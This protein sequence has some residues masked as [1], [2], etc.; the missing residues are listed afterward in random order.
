LVDTNNISIS[1][2]IYQYD[3]L[4]IKDGAG[5]GFDLKSNQTQILPSLVSGTYQFKNGSKHKFGYAILTKNQTGIKTSSRI[6]KELMLFPSLTTQEMK[7]LL[8]NLH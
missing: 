4:N 6:D 5:K 2:S 3:M 7:N 8:D 1:A